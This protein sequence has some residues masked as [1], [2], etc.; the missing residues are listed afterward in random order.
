MHSL[1]CG[2]FFVSKAFPIYYNQE[3]LTVTDE[4]KEKISYFRKMGRGYASI[5]K[6]LGISKNTIKSFCRRN[7]LAAA[8][9]SRTASVDRCRECGVEITQQPKRKKKIFCCKACRERWWTAHAD[10]IRQRAIYEF[11]C[12]NCG[13]SFT[14][15]GNCKR[16]YCSHA[17]YIAD[18]FGGDTVE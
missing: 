6:E 3:A 5:G 4:Q 1:F 12:A 2:L 7:G 10:Q 17:C 9:L 18:R 14:A 13:K 11:R 16:K 15:Y 8:D